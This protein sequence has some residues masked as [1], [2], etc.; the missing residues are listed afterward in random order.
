MLPSRQSLSA[1]RMTE[2][3]SFRTIARWVVPLPKTPAFRMLAVKFWLSWTTNVMRL[4]ILNVRSRCST[5]SHKSMSGSGVRQTIT[6]PWKGIRPWSVR[7]TGHLT[8][9]SCMHRKIVTIGTSAPGRPQMRACPHL[10]AID[11]NVFCG[12]DRTIEASWS[13]RTAQFNEGLYRQRAEGL[14]YSPNRDRTVDICDQASR[15]STGCGREAAPETAP[16]LPWCL[17]ALPLKAGSIW[18]GIASFSRVPS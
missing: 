16:A 5:A 6:R 4:A 7:H 8:T 11:L 1:L 10:V 14:G 2:Y 18:L 13:A 17:S 9:L 12:C 15:S 3:A